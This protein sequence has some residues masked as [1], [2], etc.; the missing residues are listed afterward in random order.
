MK[1]KWTGCV[2]TNI[3]IINKIPNVVYLIQLGLIILFYFSTAQKESR[4]YTSLYKKIPLLKYPI[5]Y[6]KIILE[7]LSKPYEKKIFKNE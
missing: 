3:S 7:T 6:K 5:F 1:F 4:D 2:T